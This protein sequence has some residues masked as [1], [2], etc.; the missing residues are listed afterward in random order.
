MI[1]GMVIEVCQV[2][3]H[4]EHIFINCVESV[5]K[6]N[7]KQCGVYV[8]CT[9]VSLRVEV[10]DHIWWQSGFVYWTPAAIRRDANKVVSGVDYDVRIPRIGPTCN[11]NPQW[12]AY[13]DRVAKKNRR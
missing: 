4:P 10:G 12:R 9:V 8:P 7:A 3:M 5:L 13:V 1:G 2:P 6:R 11:S